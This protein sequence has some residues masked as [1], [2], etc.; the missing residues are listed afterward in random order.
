M[1]ALI[2]GGAKRLGASLCL[3]L[4]EKGHSVVVHYNKSQKEALEVVA[5]CQN[6]GV[7]AAAI[8]GDFSSIQHV[9]EFTDRYLQQF[10]P[11]HMLINNVGHYS[12][13]STLKTSIEEWI[14]LFQINLHTP[15]FLAQA[16]APTLIQTEGQ[17][18]NIGVSGLQRHAFSTYFTAY[19]STKEALWGAT[20]ALAKELAPQGVRV[21]MVSPG[22]LDI[23]VDLHQFIH[24][25]P[26]RRPGYCWEVCNVVTFLLNPDNRYIT[27][28]NIEVSGG[29]GLK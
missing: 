13:G 25:L 17:I 11:T 5:Q 27:G 14:N 20:Q 21:N 8:Q 24:K 23:A 6:L 29:F 10:S 7:K 9:K 26:M 22:V 2:T 16:L 19:Y 1:W 4:A 12:H 15:I 3:A 28:Q 18:I